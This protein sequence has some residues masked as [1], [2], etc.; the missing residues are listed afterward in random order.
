MLNDDQKIRILEMSGK[1]LFQHLQKRH[2]LSNKQK[3][4]INRFWLEQNNVQIG[5]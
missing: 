1:E 3:M 2:D 5:R 4:E